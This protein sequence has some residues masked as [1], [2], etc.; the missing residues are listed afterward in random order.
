MKMENNKRIEYT[1]NGIT[2]KCVVKWSAGATAMGFHIE[3][4][5]PV[6]LTTRSFKYYT[7]HDGKQDN[8]ELDEIYHELIKEA[9][10][11]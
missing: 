11:N 5:E 10:S 1:Y 6:K 8:R 9:I 4:E 3:I 7:T 2:Y